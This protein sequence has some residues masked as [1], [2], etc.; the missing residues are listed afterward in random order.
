M[1]Q[2]FRNLSVA[3]LSI[4]SVM[5]FL[6]Q[7]AAAQSRT[8]CQQYAHDYANS[9]TRT[10]DN[11]VGGAVG[12]AIVGGVIGSVTGSW[13]RGAAIGG[14][15][16]AATGLGKSSVDWDRHYRYAYNRCVSGQV[17]RAPVGA[18]RPEPWSPAWYDYCRSKYRSF[19]PKTGYFTAYSGQK[20]FCR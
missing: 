2:L 18:Q 10:G 6:P 15:V 13:G 14:G 11:V 1:S 17:R 5:A 20:K 7:E 8:H 12:G 9:R 4:V 3:G 19:N 16:G